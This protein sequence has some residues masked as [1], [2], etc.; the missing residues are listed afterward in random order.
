MS[1]YGSNFFKELIQ[2]LDEAPAIPNLR[3]PAGKPNIPNLRKPGG[4]PS[5][6]AAKPPVTRAAPAAAPSGL[7]AKYQAM[8]KKLKQPSADEGFFGRNSRRTENA[9]IL[10][11]FAEDND[12]PGMYDPET[13]NF[14]YND[15][16]EDPNTGEFEKK[17]QVA[18]GGSMD[19]AKDLAGKGLVPDKVMQRFTDQLADT[20]DI[21]GGDRPEYRKDLEDIFKANAA[22]KKPV[23]P[24]KKPGAVKQGVDQAG[25]GIPKDIPA[26]VGTVPP[27]DTPGEIKPGDDP[28][29]DPMIKDLM[30]KE[31]VA[32]QDKKDADAG[33]GA[34]GDGGVSALKKFAKSGQGGLR[35][36]PK[37][38]AAIKELQRKLGLTPDGIYGKNTR[39]AVRK[40]QTAQGLTVDGDAGPNTIKAIT[41]PK[42][43]AGDNINPRA[44]QPGDYTGADGI[45]D[46]ST[47]K[48][49]P[50]SR[51]ATQSNTKNRAKMNAQRNKST[52]PPEIMNPVAKASKIPNLRDDVNESY[53]ADFFK[54]VKSI[55]EGISETQSA[56]QIIL[57]DIA[58]IALDEGP[59]EI[60]TV[61]DA[62][63]KLATTGEG[64][65]WLASQGLDISN[66]SD[67]DIVSNIVAPMGRGAYNLAGQ[68]QRN[69]DPKQLG[70]AAA[71]ADNPLTRLVPGAIAGA[72]PKGPGYTPGAQGIKPSKIDIDI[73]PGDVRTFL[74]VYDSLKDKFPKAASSLRSGNFQDALAQL[75]DRMA[76]R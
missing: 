43:D 9:E 30:R 54:T 67:D 17:V 8:L 29:D 21:F 11:K 65:Q 59:D 31:K 13:G 24:A 27:S 35:N 10:A 18:A 72:I 47:G 45:E 60:A 70:Q 73:S 62:I 38:K 41:R 7:Q 51:P 32:A 63:R 76:D 37:Q 74:S 34:V 3:E 6:P 15:E 1:T 61:S 64:K 52:M 75:Y 55:F 16:V 39:Q 33:M 36:D 71:A 23:A 25:T 19:A 42:Q 49:V 56:M 50:P 53:G 5:A 4:K 68:A 48:F 20:S 28:A 26:Q 46:F 69:I 44:D 12:L 2:K 57:E 14:V 66:M 58:L 22:S 40:F